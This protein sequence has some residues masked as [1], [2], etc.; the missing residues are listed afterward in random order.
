M[1][2]TLSAREIQLRDMRIA[3]QKRKNAVLPNPFGEEPAPAA[4]AAPPERKKAAPAPRPAKKKPAKK[5][6]SRASR[7]KS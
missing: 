6:R 1:A 3:Q 7:K 2:Y 5:K 4:A